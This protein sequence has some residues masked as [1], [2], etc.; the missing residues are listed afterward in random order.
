M[1]LLRYRYTTIE[2]FKHDFEEARVN[3]EIISEFLSEFESKKLKIIYLS[4]IGVSNQWQ[5][6]HIGPIISN[7]FE[8]LI[9]RKQEGVIIYAKLIE[10]AIEKIR[11]GYE[12]LGENYDKK[13]GK[14]YLISK[15][16]IPITK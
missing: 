3:K 6:L 1:G 4:R 10:V 11:L 5:G 13:W 12:I 15:M 14:Y 2:E 8:F 9:K 7:F 16:H